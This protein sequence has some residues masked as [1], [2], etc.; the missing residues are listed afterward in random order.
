[1]SNLELYE[2]RW[3]ML[4]LPPLPAMVVAA[5]CGATWDDPVEA[6]GPPLVTLLPPCGASLRA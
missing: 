6:S 3:F 5:I 1:M 2:L 4:R